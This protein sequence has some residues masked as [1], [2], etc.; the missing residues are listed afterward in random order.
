MGHRHPFRF[1]VINEQ[2]LPRDAWLTHVR[3][4]EEL[5]YSTFLIRDHLASDFFGPQYGPIAA[6]AT[7]AAITTELRVGTMVIANDFR[8][9]AILAKEFATL[10]ELS[11]GRV[12][13]GIGAGW[14]RAEYEQ[15]G[16]DFGPAGR[17]IA[18]LEEALQMLDGL[19][20]GEP[21]CFAGD[22]YQID[23]LTSFPRTDARRRPQLMVGGGRPRMLRLAGRF[24]DT[25]GVLASAY[26]A[27]TMAPLAA[28]R[29]CEAVREKI[30]WIREGAGSRF[31]QIELSMIPTIIV[32]DD[33]DA[34]ALMVIEQHNWDGYN[35]P[36]V[37]AM[38]SMLIG[39]I[40]DIIDAL[41][42]R[43][44][45]YGFSYIVVSDSQMDAFAPV[46]A[47]LSG[48]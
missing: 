31:E 5:G 7:A 4:V 18:R 28:E 35:A 9:P 2:P 40:E 46:V 12:E 11:G 6:L 24:A 34:A 30:S 39:S 32:T 22:H 41:V 23:G 47:A 3:R 42:Q 19:W 43:R 8:H 45:E 38:P 17:R 14:M 15:A 27:G 26:G 21:V 48:R 20:H 25:V 16:F 44:E 13:L 1:G 33:R 37:L 29:T 10:A 36:D